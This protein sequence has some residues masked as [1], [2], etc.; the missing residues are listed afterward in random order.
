MLGR[1]VE[2]RRQSRE[3]SVF[4]VDTSRS[5]TPNRKEIWRQIRKDLQSAGLT[6]E[7]FYRNKSQ[8]VTLLRGNLPEHELEDIQTEDMDLED[9]TA[10]IGGIEHDVPIIDLTEEPSRSSSL[11]PTNSLYPV[12]GMGLGNDELLTDLTE[13]PS[14]SFSVSR[15][16]RL[17]TADRNLTQN[18]PGSNLA[19]VTFSTDKMSSVVSVSRGSIYHFG[20]W[21]DAD[22]SFSPKPGLYRPYK[23]SSIQE[24]V[25]RVELEVQHRW[26]KTR[27]QTMLQGIISG[28][29]LVDDDAL[30]SIVTIANKAFFHEAL[31]GRVEWHWSQEYPYNWACISSTGVRPSANGGYETSI[32]LSAR[33]RALEQESE[34]RAVLIRVFLHELIQCFLFISCGI[35][36]GRW[37]ERAD[38]IRNIAEALDRWIEN[39]DYGLSGTRGIVHSGL[40]LSGIRMTRN[41][42]HGEWALEQLGTRIQN[43]EHRT[44]TPIVICVNRLELENRIYK[45]H[46]N[47]Q[48]A[49]ND[50]CKPESMIGMTLSGSLHI[51]G[52]VNSVT[53]LENERVVY[54]AFDSRTQHWYAVKTI[55]NKSVHLRQYERSL[56]VHYKASAHPNI[57]SLLKIGDFNGFIY[58]VMPYYPEG[59][60]FDCITQSRKHFDDDSIRNTFLQLLDAVEHCHQLGV[61][62]LDLKPEHILVSGDRILLAGFGLSRTEETAG[63]LGTT[64][65]ASPGTY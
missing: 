50:H 17:R 20:H 60:L 4:S 51:L 54:K 55:N 19:T 53:C 29:W 41:Y 6:P 7:I 9:D 36:D 30:D 49:C 40:N 64:P 14:Q 5:L 12:D 1:F 45:S 15:T 3:A 10:M 35:R 61:Y 43:S 37:N 24:A 47:Q 39:I 21:R 58:T 31:S 56:C 32:M 16:N 8:I 22:N 2:V 42:I 52:V 25:R 44:Y 34:D 33:L 62:H 59:N 63:G 65:Y 11:M 48:S 13:E 38:A 18:E 28:T 26:S 27:L 46:S 23:T 57:I